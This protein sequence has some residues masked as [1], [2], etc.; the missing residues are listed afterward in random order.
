MKKIVYKLVAVS[1]I[2]LLLPFVLTLIFTKNKKVHNSLESM[3][4]IIY[5]EKDGNRQKLDFD[6]YLIGIVAT[7]MPAGYHIEALKAQAV[8]SRTY[9]LY[10]ISMLSKDNPSRKEYTTAELGLSYISLDEMEQYWGSENYVN[11]FTKL[12]NCVYSTKDE[13]LLYDNDLI[14]P[15]FFGTG[16]GHTRSA[17]DAWGVDIPYLKSVSSKQD[18][19]SIHYLRITEHDPG[20]LI[21]ILKQVYP[22]L[23]L[24]EESFFKSISITER[25]SIGYVTE[26]AI[27]NITISGEEF[28]NILG[29]NSNHFY[30]ED[31]EGKARIICT[32]VGHGVGLSQYGANAMAEEGYPYNEILLHYYTDVRL[33][34]L[35]N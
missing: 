21:G 6:Q 32:G 33:I 11:Y 9:A 2:V 24:T 12:E 14:L 20:L 7:N 16:T 23:E 5:Y 22:S 29:L 26:V 25:D 13:I 19:T 35:N 10:N 17:K 1:V 27:D 34:N 18:V 15:V 28:A 8:I 4:Y 30:I 31:Y 3:D